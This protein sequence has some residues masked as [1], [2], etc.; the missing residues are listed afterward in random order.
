MS[1]LPGFA[2]APSE[3]IAL[4]TA[5]IECQVDV[6]QHFLVRDKIVGAVRH[7]IVARQEVHLARVKHVGQCR[8]QRGLEDASL[9]ASRAHLV[10]VLEEA[11]EAAA[12]MF[13]AVNYLHS[14]NIVHRD[15]KLE[16][17]RGLVLV[18]ERISNYMKERY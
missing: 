5:W 17:W 6:V 9:D 11:A 4:E 15:L 16:N 10:P 3:W 1:N 18:N 14:H 8:A 7:C 2:F 13:T 12:Q